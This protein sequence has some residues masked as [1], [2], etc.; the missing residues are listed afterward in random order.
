MTRARTHGSVRFDPYWKVQF[1]RPQDF[2]WQD[3]QAQHPTEEAAR[4]AYL[5]GEVCRLMLVTER[6][7]GP[8]P[9][10]MSARPCEPCADHGR[11]APAVRRMPMSIDA[12][13][14]ID[15]VDACALHARVWWDGADWDGRALEQALS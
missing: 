10:S 14:T 7:R 15:Y 3:V 4:A 8:V 12:G 11:D 6:G 2:S 1:F 13:Q 5:P 9:G